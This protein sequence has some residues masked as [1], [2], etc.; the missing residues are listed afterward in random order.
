MPAATADPAAKF[1]DPRA[2]ARVGSLELRTRAAVE[3]MMSGRHRSPLQGSSVEFAQHRPYVQ[4]D[5]TRH[6]DWKVFGRS[7]KLHIKQ[8]QEETQL[9]IVLVV[10]ASESMAFGSV[11]GDGGEPWTKFD[12]ATTLAATMAYLAIKQTDAVGLGVFDN[13]LTKYVRPGTTTGQWR[14]IANELQGTP[15]VN[16]TGTGKILETLGGKLRGRSLV[17]LV[18]DFF[19]DLAGLRRGLK[20]LR[21]RKHEVV[22]CQLLDPQE[23]TFPFEDVTMFQGMESAG[24]LLTEPRALRQGYLNVLAE[25]TDD[26][27]KLCRGVDIDFARFDTGESLG[28][29]LSA[30]LARRAAMAG[31]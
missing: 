31:R 29:P 19:D 28:V 21:F 3:G 6:I 2:L 26:L 4:G 25:F 10:D 8:F 27:K 24:E 14:T 15:R 30:L 20:A 11:K 7:D 5:D 22:C 9:Q 1:L 18:S 17:I 12:F 16:K 13:A 23:I